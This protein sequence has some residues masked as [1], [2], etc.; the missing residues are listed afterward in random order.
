M[1][2]K[3]KKD[4]KILIVDDEESIVNFLKASMEDEGFMVLQTTRSEKAVEICRDDAPEL[5]ILD[6]R[7]PHMD[8]MQMLRKIREN[9][10]GNEILAILI[11]AYGAEMS[12]EDKNILKALDIKDFIPKGVSLFEAKERIFKVIEAK[13]HIK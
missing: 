9:D 11:S 2:T 3:K 12:D 6:L 5:L 13:Y 8:G 10:R 1:K 7:M 4:L